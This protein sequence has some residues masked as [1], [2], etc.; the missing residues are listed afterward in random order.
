MPFEQSY[1]KHDDQHILIHDHENCGLHFHSQD[2]RDKI[3]FVQCMRV[4]EAPTPDYSRHIAYP[5]HM[6]HGAW[7][8]DHAH[9]GVPQQIAHFH[10]PHDDIT[11]S[12]ASTPFVDN[13]KLARGY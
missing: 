9:N 5:D 4:V 2:E 12:T 6:S 10:K 13:T 11:W 3:Y 7:H 1:H 8:N